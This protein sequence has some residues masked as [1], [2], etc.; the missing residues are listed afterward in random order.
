VIIVY[1]YSGKIRQ[2]SINDLTCEELPMDRRLRRLTAIAFAGALATTLAIP[3]NAA[4]ETGPALSDVA[5]AEMLMA[6]ERDLG[7]TRAE[8]IDLLVRDYEAIQLTEQL[9]GTLGDAYAGSWINDDGRLVVA[10][11][12]ASGVATVQRAG[13]LAQ[14]VTRS[15]GELDAAVSA[16]DNA[17]APAASDVY[18]WYVDVVANEVV[19]EANARTSRGTLQRWL[20]QSGVDMTMVRVAYIT[21]DAPQTYFDIVG[22]WPYFI[23]GSRCSVGFA[24]QPRGFVTAGHCGNVGQSTTGHNGAAQGQFVHSVFPGADA[25]Y[26]AVNSN[27][28]LHALVSRYDGTFAPVNGSAVAPV[29]ALVC[30]SGSTSGYRCGNILAFNQTVNYPQG[31]VNGLTLTSACAAPGDSGGSFIAAGI[32]AQGVTSGGSGFCGSGGTPRTFFQPV[33]P[34]LNSWGLTL[35]TQ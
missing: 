1:D 29:N 13:G 14:L 21:D 25:A 32:N 15:G 17:P 6:V 35:V 11:S 23:G 10:V 31:Q 3:S 26:V 5:T 7:L 27:W 20:A 8:A 19:V 4:A 28:R 16:L 9:T 12:E 22:G 33:N 30:R 34:M 2:M 18:S 24:V